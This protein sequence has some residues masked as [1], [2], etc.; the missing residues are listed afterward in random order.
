MRPRR[1]LELLLASKVMPDYLGADYPR[2]YAACKEAE[3]D[4]F[5]WLISP[6]E[7]DWYLQAD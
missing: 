3:Y 2:L 4:E 7:Y 1:A 5:D 6:Q